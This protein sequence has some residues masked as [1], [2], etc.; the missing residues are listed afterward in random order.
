MSV[1][2]EKERNAQKAFYEKIEAEMGEKRSE[3]L[4][5]WMKVSMVYNPIFALTFVV[6]YWIIGLRHALSG[7]DK[8]K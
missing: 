6:V 1:N 2:E 4:S 3:K 8:L 5:F 7:P